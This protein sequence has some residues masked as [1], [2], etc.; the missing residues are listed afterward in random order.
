MIRDE[1]NVYS[2]EQEQWDVFTLRECTLERDTQRLLRRLDALRSL[3]REDL[4]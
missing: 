1:R 2:L 3:D 4:L